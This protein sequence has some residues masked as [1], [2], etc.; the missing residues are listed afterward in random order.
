MGSIEFPGPRYERTP[1]GRQMLEHF[2]LDPTYKEMNNGSFGS[3]PTVILNKAHELRKR[4]EG[5]PAIF[6][7]YEYPPGLDKSREAV[8]KLL[9]AAPGNIVLVANG[10]T[11]SNTIMRNFAWNDDGKDEIIQVSIIFAPLG[12]MTGYVGELNPGKVRT[13]QVQLNYP[14][15]DDEVVALFRAGIQASREA[16][17]R[18][19][20]GIFDT[21]ASIPGIRLPFE[22]L[23]AL[24]RE[25]G[26]LSFIDG[27][28]AAGHLSI[29]LAALDPDFFV[30]CCHKWLFVPRGCAALYV[31]PRHQSMIRST[32]PLSHGFI[33][34]KDLEQGKVDPRLAKD[35]A[36]G[37][38]AFVHNFEFVAPM[39]NFGYLCIPESIRWR[40]EV[41]GG[42]KAIMA[43]C[44]NLAREGG[45]A[46][47]DILGTHVLD[48]QSGS[49]T[50]CCMT[51]IQLPLALDGDSS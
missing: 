7:R 39:D 8:A 43:Y 6:T 12:K 47:A 16:G 23:T 35:L 42:E 33:P 26:V 41:C 40:Q 10:S 29:D 1:F 36:M 11:G 19:R 22:R 48:N 20:L 27:A 30:T 44:V 9:N 31:P 18:P 49:M 14:M 25:E 45:Q 37:K 13:R 50:A 32:L 46:I 51:N 5:R 28:H 2:S 17:Y 38:N 15:E 4:C 24:C 34:T 3:V 21:I